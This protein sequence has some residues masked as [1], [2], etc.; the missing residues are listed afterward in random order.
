MRRQRVLVAIL[1]YNGREFVPA[2]L[3]SAAGLQAGGRHVDVLVLDDC[4]PD[5][6]WS[7]D[8]AGLCAG[9]GTGYYRSP[10]NLGIPRN[11]N[12]ALLRALHGGYD[13]VMLVNSDVVL[14]INLLDGMLGAAGSGPDIGSVTAWS[15][16]VS[17]FSLPNHDQT[18][19]LVRQDVVDW[20]SLQLADQFGPVAADLPT[21]V[22]YCLLLPVPVVAEVGLMD[23]VY[24][25]GY[26]EEVDWCQRSRARGY[27]AVLAPS[28]FVF[29]HGGRSTTDAGLVSGLQRTVAEHERI[30]DQRH[31]G[32]RRDVEDFLA[33]DPLAP[34]VARALWVL[35][36]GAAQRWGYAVEARRL[37]GGPAEPADAEI[38]HAV[39]DPD[40]P[41]TVTAD[42]RGFRLA[43]PVDGGDVATTLRHHFGGP[44]LRVSVF[45]R[46]PLAMD[47]AAG[48]GA[49]VPALDRYGY[50]E[51]V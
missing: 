45:D 30:V 8:L 12:L 4:S 40:R 7:R 41:G 48:F 51:R 35:V 31:P 22:G 44:P 25:R 47:W 50:P 28:T 34:L 29:H 46:G 11:M 42:Y 24:G 18:G 39:V 13:H 5:E 21:G 27:R 36:I 10:R 9:L 15:N 1:V 38:V 33:A 16:N 2:C 14:P 19:T 20:V 37:P 26:C 3:Q 17:V 6:A 23:P 49:A 43:L 32:Y